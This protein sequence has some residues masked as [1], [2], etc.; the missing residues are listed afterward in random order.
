MSR[1]TGASSEPGHEP[2]L[3]T[4][5][6]R[7]ARIALVRGVAEPRLNGIDFVE[8]LSNHMG[9]PGHVQDTPQQ[10]TLAVHL[11]HAPVPPELGTGAG[12]PAVVIMG[13]VRPDP[14]VNPVLVE[15]AYP[16]VALAGDTMHS[17][18]AGLP[19][20]TDGDRA[21]VA[22]SVPEPARARVL[23]VRTTTSGDRSTYVLRLR[24]RLGAAAPPH[25]DEP[26]SLAP[27]AFGVDCPNEL[28]CREQPL[29][30]D[31]Y[32][33]SPVLDYLARDYEA[34]R[35]RLLDRLAVLLPDWTDRSPADIGITLVELFSYLGDRLAYWQDAI[36]NEAY[37]GTARRR[38]SV[39]RH[40]RLLD[41]R[42]HEGCSARAWLA[43]TIERGQPP[44]KLPRGT[45]VADVPAG[46]EAGPAGTKN[47]VQEA[48][49]SGAV[50]FETC[51]PITLVP[52]R[53]R[54]NLHAWG[55]PDRVL[56][57][58]ST[59]A[60]LVS[61]ELDDPP[62]LRAGEVLVLAETGLSGE[63]ADGDPGRRFAVRLIRDP[64]EHTD[65]LSTPSKVL[66]VHWHRDDALPL[67]L[68][69]SRRGADGAAEVAAMAWANVTLADH[70]VTL[71]D[72]TLNPPRVPQGSRYRPR[73]PRTG[74]AW[75][76]PV[77][78][79][80]AERAADPS[81]WESAA[82]ALRPD[83]LRAV[84]QVELDDGAR[85]WE[86]RLDLFGSSRVAPHL[87]VEQEPDGVSV[88]R[89]GD[90]TT[91]RR[92][93]PGT[94][95]TARYRLGGGTR[96]NVGGD[97]LRRFLS[98]PGATE[99]TG[100]AVTN[101]LAASGGTA[102]Q[103]LAEVRE[104]APQTPRS[105][106]R[107][108]TSVDY[109]RIAMR[110]SA[111]Q[112]AVGRQRWTGSWYAQEVALDPVAALAEDPDVPLLLAKALETRRMAG[113]DVELARAVA[114]PLDIRMTCCLAAGYLRGQVE[115]RLRDVFSS[116]DLAD[117]GR[118]FFHPDNLAF[119]RPVFLSDLLG[120]A[121]SVP[122][123]TL[124]EVDRFARVG[125][126]PNETAQALARGRLEAAAREVF[127]CDSDPD[128][129]ESG[130]VDLVLRGGT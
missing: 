60:F 125:A 12:D 116:H 24:G 22:T 68:R 14:R 114:V 31:R 103:P 67:S 51:D 128:R 40:A 33:P 113:V 25:F 130:K 49:H 126:H 83:P 10:R 80:P 95:F 48:V 52:S 16:A 81:G 19:G 58:G 61:A 84:P 89:F 79:T 76:E 120:R 64:V 20:V 100:V 13:G 123:V 110:D 99:L 43:F 69:V 34:L 75:A 1:S 3:S 108:V 93:A 82:A 42:V 124:V 112:G 98:H 65:P 56:P 28:D 111:V 78:A 72:E 57:A 45:P 104:L 85:R 115:R 62:E 90:G 36:A 17:A 38:T 30:V 59:S 77:S 117:G 88:L 5:V 71:S 41:Y 46:Q 102:P 119:G 91:G 7:A 94:V 4:G 107:A 66:E 55:D 70:G 118:G 97:S 54:V 109:A 18:E 50:V 2:A 86:P 29:D 87:V 74:L 23:I 37:L 127:R 32:P 63:P 26:L 96:G 106:Q 121:M 27:F 129:P 8:V 105:G 15:W 47:T 122:G 21:L 73:L 39:S 11:L 35:V 101:P 53:N 92:P 6:D 9:T 44:R